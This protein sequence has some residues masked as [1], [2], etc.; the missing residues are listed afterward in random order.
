LPTDIDLGRFWAARTAGNV[1]DPRDGS[2][3]WVKEGAHG[4][5]PQLKRKEWHSSHV[6]DR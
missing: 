5:E 6:S 4:P 1:D 3:R 2:G